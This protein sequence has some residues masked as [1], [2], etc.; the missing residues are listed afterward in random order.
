[1][2]PV[3]PLAG[4][5][6]E[7]HLVHNSIMDGNPRPHKRQRI[8]SSPSPM[9]AS[10]DYYSDLTS[11][12]PSSNPALAHQPLSRTPSSEEGLRPIPTAI[13][14]VSLPALLA[15]PPNHKYYVH[16]LVLSLRALRKCLT[17]PALPP[18]IECRAWTGLAELGMRVISGGF[19]QSDEHVWARGIESEVRALIFMFSCTGFTPEFCLQVEK[20]LSRGVSASI[21]RISPPPPQRIEKM[22]I[23]DVPTPVY[24]RPEGA[25]SS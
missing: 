7:P 20:A 19:S 11:L 16:S 4:R 22:L 15:H 18:D 3:P 1:M 21:S 17:L 8:H 12:P 24:H 13:L 23:N 25:V 14:L 2:A 5:R 10:D 6:K 9:P